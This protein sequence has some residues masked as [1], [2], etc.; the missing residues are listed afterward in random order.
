[1]GNI[2]VLKGANNW[3]FYK[4]NNSL[5]NFQNKTL[6]T[7]EELKIIAEYLSNIDEWCRKHN[8][9]FY[10]F[11]A[12]DKNKVYGE[13][14]TILKK[15]RP[16]SESRANQ[17]INYLRKNTKVNV[18]YPIDTLLKNKKKGLLYYKHDTHWNLFGAYFGYLEL[19]KQ[20]QKKYKQVQPIKYSKLETSHMETGDL[21][22][23]INYNVP[24]D[25]S[26][27]FIPVIDKKA[28]CKFNAKDKDK[29][30]G[31]ECS[32]KSK[33]LNAII[34]RDSFTISLEEYLSNTFNK[35]K[36]EWKAEI[37]SEDKKDILK[38]FDIV[39]LE[40]VERY[41]PTILNLKFSKE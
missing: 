2:K 7:D 33:K 4:R 8:K 14:I 19:I 40:N 15:L 18:I 20:I 17:L 30:K 37:S 13:H 26:E 23:M 27:Y 36:F 29:K 1:M 39:I 21:D 28:V 9:S 32:N 25:K 24:K 22:P 34:F 41:I 38:N 5:D 11:I 10:Y 31:F 35:M 6:L 16:D 3:L 12:P